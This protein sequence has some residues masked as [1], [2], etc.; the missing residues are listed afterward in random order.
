MQEAQI[1]DFL[2]KYPDTI[3]EGLKVL[4]RQR[5]TELGIIDLLC[6]DKTGKYVIKPIFED[7]GKF[8]EGLARVR[9][10]DE[11]LSYLMK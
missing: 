8:S 7:A 2:E 1:E 6:K 4:D 3:E 5:R 11:S 10:F 9:V